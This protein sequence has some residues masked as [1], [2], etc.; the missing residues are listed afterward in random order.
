MPAVATVARLT[1][2]LITIVYTLCGITH[3]GVKY[4]ATC[5]LIVLIS[6][7]AVAVVTAVVDRQ[8]VF[9]GCH[10]HADVQHHGRRRNRR[11]Y[12]PYTR[13]PSS[14]RTMLFSLTCGILH[15]LFV[16]ALVCITTIN[17][18]IEAA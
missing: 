4:T 12:W 14:T 1:L 16:I 6:I 9:F 17:A 18:E 5:G 13:S 7:V 10:G 3:C 11:R 2:L 15:L 8:C